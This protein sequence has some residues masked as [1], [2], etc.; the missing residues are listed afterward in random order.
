MESMI[1]NVSVPVAQ[2]A[3]VELVT[4]SASASASASVSA[5]STPVAS[6]ELDMVSASVSAEVEMVQ[7]ASVSAVV[8]EPDPQ[9][10]ESTKEY[11]LPPSP[12]SLDTLQTS[13]S[14]TAP[15]L[16]ASPEESQ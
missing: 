4:V 16:E 10:A 2:V 14:E 1:N 8:S 12:V 15:S 13:E 7:Q 6:V 11:A 3:L 9:A 5:V